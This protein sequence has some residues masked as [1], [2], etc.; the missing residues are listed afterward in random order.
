MGPGPGA[1][2]Q[3]QTQASRLPAGQHAGESGPRGRRV[4]GQG[5]QGSPASLFRRSGV[6]LQL[7]GVPCRS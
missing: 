5:L 6:V 7:Q 1:P 2:T 3:N 4:P